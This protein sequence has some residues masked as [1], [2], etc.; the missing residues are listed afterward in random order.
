M[1]AKYSGRGVM[2]CVGFWLTEQV[3]RVDTFNDPSFVNIP[4]IYA[5]VDE[6]V[7]AIM[8]GVIGLAGV[9]FSALWAL[10][11]ANQ[12]ISMRVLGNFT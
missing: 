7:E 6:D 5:S 2:Q 4:D 1:N 3:A 12:G 10:A 9:R 11:K 8:A